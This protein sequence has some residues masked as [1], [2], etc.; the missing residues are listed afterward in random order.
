MLVTVSPVVWVTLTSEM[1]LA[2]G[3]AFEVDLVPLIK[4]SVDAKRA[5]LYLGLPDGVVFSNIVV[6][7]LD[8]HIVADL[9]NVD[10]EAFTPFG[11]LAGFFLDRSF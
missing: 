7:H 4:S 5:Q 3:L 9:L 8:S 1:Y 10:V 11:F 2:S 6:H